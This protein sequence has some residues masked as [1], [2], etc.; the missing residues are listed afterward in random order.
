MITDI[1]TD[2]LRRLHS[3]YPDHDNGVAAAAAVAANVFDMDQYYDNHRRHH[4]MSQVS[5][6]RPLSGLSYLLSEDD[7]QCLTNKFRAS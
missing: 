1:I 2:P 5:T 4:I 7:D 3:V 6:R